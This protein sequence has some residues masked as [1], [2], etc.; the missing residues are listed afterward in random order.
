MTYRSLLVHLDS[1]SH[2]A[3]R[4]QLAIRIARQHDCHL[5]G[6][7]PTG[8]VDMPVAP[9]AAASLAEFAAVAWDALRDRAEAATQ[10]FRDACRV[11][12]CKSFEAVVDERDKAQ[13]IVRHA[14]CSDLV[15]LSQA[16]PDAPG[17]GL[18]QGVV[19]Q[20]V[21][22]SARPTLVIPYAGRFDEPPRTALVAWDDS[23][24]A[25]R[26]V[27]DALPLLRVCEKVQVVAWNESIGAEDT[28]MAPRLD[29][30]HKWLMWQGVN[31]QVRTESTDIGIAEAMLSRAAP[32]FLH[33]ADKLSGHGVLQCLH[34]P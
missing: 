22:N 21:L 5:V 6:L 2:C 25:S 9:E 1:D 19:E 14:H 29:A 26:A 13:S 16:E 33:I 23:R 18:A 28:T 12:E 17:Y 10:M 11:A 3:A 8:L 31:S 24:E 4:T 32:Q 15:I 27:A 34:P 7:A 30:L 20:V